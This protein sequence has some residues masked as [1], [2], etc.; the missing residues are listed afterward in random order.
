[1]SNNKPS[2][3]V[4]DQ[5]LYN[6]VHLNNLCFEVTDA[7]NLACKYCGYRDLYIDYD[8]RH[9]INM[10]FGVGKRLIDYLCSIWRDNPS[11]RLKNQTVISFYGGEPLINSSFIRE[12]VAYVKSLDIDRKFE[13]G[14]T[15]NAMLLDKQMDFLAQNNFRLLI[16]LDGDFRGNAYR[17]TKNGE[18]S[19][20]KVFSNCKK[21]MYQYPSYFNE[22]VSFNAVLHNNNSV[23]SIRRFIQEEF[24]K[25]PRISEVNPKGLNPAKRDEFLALYKSKAESILQE[26]NSELIEEDLFLDNP[27]TSAIYKQLLKVCGNVIGDYSG[28]LY[29]DAKNK[30]NKPCGG[31]CTPFGK[32]LFL[33]VSGKIFQCERCGQYYPLGVVDENRVNLDIKNVAEVVNR[34]LTKAQ[35]VCSG[36]ADYQSCDTCVYELTEFNSDAPRCPYF[37]TADQ[38]AQRMKENREYLADHPLIYERLIKSLHVE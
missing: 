7:C 35:R 28:L 9:G 3:I 34:L 21:L 2:W 24:G 6:L 38:K 29:N 14:M 32:K 15:T 37:I 36:C 19:F 5:V 16:S 26:K 33:A 12:M 25:E 13:F 20:D 18:P 1:M 23:S 30:I 10:P 27:R 31:T 8:E 11:G 22:Q 17:V 4:P